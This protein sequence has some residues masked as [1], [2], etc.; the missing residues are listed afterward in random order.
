MTR[1]LLIVALL[2]SP[3]IK[4]DEA[5][6][7]AAREAR[8]ER[9]RD[10]MAKVSERLSEQRER[11]GGVEADLARL[12]R[13][14]NR[15]RTALAQLDEQ[16]R[17]TSAQVA[18]RQR[19]LSQRRAEAKAHQAFL[20]ATVRAAYRRGDASTLRLLLGDF[21]PAELQRLLVYR[22]RLGAARAE[23]ITRAQTAVAALAAERQAL[24][25]ALAEQRRV[26][27]AREDALA[28]V[29]S[30]LNQRQALLAEL[31]ARIDDDQAALAS[32]REQAQSLSELIA[33]LREQ[34]AQSGVPTRQLDDLGRARGALSWPHEGPLLAR[35]GGER[36][37]GLDWTGLLIGGRAGAPVNPI[38]AGQVVFADWLRGLGLLVIVDHGGGYL[39]LYGRNQALYFDVGD[40]VAPDDVIAT[41][42]RSGGRPETALY[43][44]LRAEG[45]PVDPLAWLSPANQSG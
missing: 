13:R 10:N 32:Q 5:S 40:Y 45:E 19:A 31:E 34:L 2:F 18:E 37:A 3:L 26:R 35:Y 38:A 9:L 20:A 28:Q 1:L 7:L 4:A 24:E 39:S 8:L 43:F 36:A 33:S 44:E 23:R 17:S 16:I 21:N 6:D 42:G 30:S 12:E 27:T 14:L 11:A 29:Q 41:V 25:Q 15:E 22:Q